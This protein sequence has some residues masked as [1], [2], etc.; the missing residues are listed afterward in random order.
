V[1][2]A[3]IRL[4]VETYDNHQLQ[5]AEAAILEGA[6][7]DIPIEGKDEGE[8]LTHVMAALWIIQQMKESDDDLTTALRAYALR[9][10]SSIG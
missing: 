2:I 10:R 3:V 5:Q 1:N 4:L 9:V 7:P 6:A 8:Q